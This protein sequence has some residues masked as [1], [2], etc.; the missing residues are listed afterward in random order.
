MASS[1]LPTI[2]RPT[3][4]QEVTL[5]TFNTLRLEHEKVYKLVTKFCGAY[6]VNIL[7]LGPCTVY[8][9]DDGDPA[10]NDPDSETLPPGSADNLLLVPE[11]VNG[12]R[13]LAGAPCVCEVLQE[14]ADPKCDAT[15]P[16]IGRG[17]TIT[18]RL[19]RG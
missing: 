17:A 15:E 7:N 3:A 8:L 14:I 6:Y 1:K 10:V 18:V 12:L 11:G 5:Q 19:V 9:R 4:F 16:E 13:V 2:P